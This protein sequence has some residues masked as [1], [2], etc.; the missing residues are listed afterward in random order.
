MSSELDSRIRELNAA[1]GQL[2]HKNDE[3]VTAAP[4]IDGVTTFSV[5]MKSAFDGNMAKMREIKETVKRL[6]SQRDEKAWASLPIGGPSGLAAEARHNAEQAFADAQEK[7]AANNPSQF[8]T[9]GQLFTESAEFKALKASGGANMA[10]PYVY[11]GQDLGSR[12]QA[13]GLTNMEQKDVYSAAPTGGPPL[14]F[15]PLYR[16]DIVVQAFRKVRVRDLFPVQA[17]TAAVIEFFRVTGF[18]AGNNAAPTPERLADNSNFGIAPHTPLN[19]QGTQSQVRMIAHWE[20]AHRNVLNDVP[21]LQGIIDTELLYGLRLA[22]DNQ[23][24]NGTGSG[25]DLLGILNTPSVQTYAALNGGVSGNRSGSGSGLATDT[26][27]DDIRRSATKAI[28]AYYEP[29]GV[30]VHPSDWEAIETLKDSTLAY[31]IAIAVAVGAEQ[32][33]WRLPV[34]DT[35]AI[36]E[37]TALVGSFG[38]GAKLYDREEGTIRV[39]EQ[40]LD[41]FLR[42]AIVV[43]AE[44]RLALTVPRPE[45]FVAITLGA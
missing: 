2:D 44:E 20:A 17:T 3:I 8:K 40:H 39:A 28:L 27:A 19:F 35:P 24:L 15:K 23:I 29:T 43:L 32:R 36:A 25:E 5:E 34:V 41:F 6:E 9:M 21:Q 11:R 7:S 30:V 13:K 4:V 33:L 38:L 45:S 37:G 22:E 12:F 16:E 42:Q 10:Q 14:G 26:K 1:W 18:V 31:I